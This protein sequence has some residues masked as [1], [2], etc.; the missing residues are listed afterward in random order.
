MVSMCVDEKGVKILKREGFFALV[1]TFALC[2]TACA[3]NQEVN[4]AEES[5]ERDNGDSISNAGGEMVPTVGEAVDADAVMK[6]M[7]A[8]DNPE[9]AAS[10]STE[11]S[12]D[13]E[14]QSGGKGEMLRINGVSLSVKEAGSGPDMVL[15]HGRGFAKDSM[16]ILFQHYQD[17]FH[18]ISYDVRGH[19]ETIAPGEFTLDDLA[20]D[21]AGL[22][23]SYNLERPIVIGFSMGSYITLR[24]AEKYP[25]LFSKIVLIGTRG[26]RTSSGL[27]VTD[28]VARALERFDNLTDAPNVSV[29]ALVLTGE[30]DAINPPAEGEKVAVALPDARFEMIPNAEHTAYVSEPD[31]V[32]TLIDEFLNET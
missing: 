18:V 13:S 12:S 23:S 22:I 20:E 8:N 25:N 24:A 5:I 32:L 31:R 4:G 16:D 21:L 27:P 28:E 6:A 17:R 15:I 29:P 19:G 14:P 30:H 9:E 10:A 26:G 1:L 7:E 11:T 3:G 2:L